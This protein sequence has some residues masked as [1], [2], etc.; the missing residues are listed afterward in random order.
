M[1]P[2]AL[3]RN[4][5]IIHIGRKDRIPEYLKKAFDTAEEKTKN[6]T[7]SVLSLAVD[8]AGQ[9]QELR[10]YKRMIKD[11]IKKITPEIM[12]SYRD[13]GGIVPPADLIIRTSGEKRISDLGWLST[14]SELSFISKLLPNI[15]SKDIVESIIDY[16]K[17]ERRFGGRP[18][19]NV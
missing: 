4:A 7:G 18:R 14:N 1:L 12:A 9:D 3:A 5:R 17:R 6:N 11:N 19:I 16:S 10:M 13:G 15:G 2:S 8:Y